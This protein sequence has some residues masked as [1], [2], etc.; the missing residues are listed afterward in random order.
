MKPTKY[1][2]VFIYLILPILAKSQSAG[3]NKYFLT[4]NSSLQNQVD[5]L[6]NIANSY[7]MLGQVP[8]SIEYYNKALQLNPND[9]KAFFNRGNSYFDLGINTKA[10]EDWQKAKQL[11][12]KEA[13]M[14]FWKFCE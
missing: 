8:I 6:I 10:C 13:D 2:L 4:L 5:S 1:I 3:N 9:A 12:H 14:S 7:Y 11:G